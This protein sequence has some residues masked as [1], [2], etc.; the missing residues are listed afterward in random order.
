MSEQQYLAGIDIGTTGA[1]TLI[2]DL[3]GQAV[4]AMILRRGLAILLDLAAK[5]SGS[6]AIKRS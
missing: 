3:D 6:T 5:S 1:K 2:V 4:A